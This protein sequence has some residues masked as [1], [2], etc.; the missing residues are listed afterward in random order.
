MAQAR[1]LGSRE[2]VPA[3]Q[4]AY[5]RPVPDVRQWQPQDE[6]EAQARAVF[7]PAIVGPAAS[8]SHEQGSAAE[9]DE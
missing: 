8:C 2:R 3:R 9:M 4:T 7:M 6:H 1:R 5:E